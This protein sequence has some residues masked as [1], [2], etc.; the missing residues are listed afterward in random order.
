ME[1]RR[2]KS[3][4]KQII[5]SEKKIIQKKLNIKAKLEK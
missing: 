4:S 3:T 5:F 2:E 1:E